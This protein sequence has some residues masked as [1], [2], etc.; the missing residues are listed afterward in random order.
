M[1]LRLKKYRLKIIL[2]AI[3]IIMAGLCV[4]SLANYKGDTQNQVN[5]QRFGSMD[6]RASDSPQNPGSQNP[7]TQQPQAQDP[8]VQNPQS[9]NQLGQNHQLQDSRGQRPDG[10]FRGFWSG[11]RNAFQNSSSSTKYVLEVIVYA[12][13]FFGIFVFAYYFFI[14]KKTAPTPD[15]AGALVAA[16][17]ISGLLF[18][19]IL[20]TV[21]EGYS[22]DISIFKGWATTAASS[23]GKVYESGSFCDYPPLYIYVL[24]LIGRL[25]KISAISPYFTILIKL[26]SIMADVATSYLIFRLAKKYCSAGISVVLAGFYLFNPAILVN[27]AI[28]GQV[29]SFFTLL[30]VGAIVLL[31][32]G[33]IA[34][35]SVVFT[36]SI[37]MKPQGIIFLP[38]LFFEL[39]RRKSVKAFLKAAGTALI[40][41]VAVVLPF[42][43]RSNPFWIV[44]LF[45][46]TLGEYRYASVNAF[47]FFGLVK[48]NYASDDKTFLNLSYHLWGMA[49]IVTITLITWI[50]YIKGKN[51]KYASLTAMLLIAGVFTFSTRMHE[52][53]LFPAVALSILAY[54][55]LQDRRFIFV[56]AGYS[57]TVFINTYYVLYNTGS[58]TFTIGYTPVLIMTSLLNIL[59]FAYT[60]VLA[61]RNVNK[62]AA[63]ESEAVRPE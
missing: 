38:V 1:V 20:T 4:Y 43:A 52:R 7:Q 33:K 34:W 61:F 31:S 13:L 58:G 2:F 6:R 28:W 53:Y 63:G 59:L 51:I 47:N 17:I 40:T 27:S 56:T 36:A 44:K 11:N 30:I 22:M 57:L 24:S 19:I 54:I 14:R 12:I 55:Y 29:D 5:V 21:M 25:V 26:P 32:E 45:L 39:V 8:K 35:S 15:N 16:L 50:I 41:A 62:A 60:V 9:Q 49:A 42:T 37:L 46:S 23:L 3:T 10:Q 18:R 48:A